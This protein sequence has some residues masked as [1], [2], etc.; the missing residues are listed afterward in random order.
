MIL[1]LAGEGKTDMG[2]MILHSEGWV[3]EPGPMAWM[4]DHLLA[5]QMGYSLIENHLSGA[6]CICYVSETDL[7]AQAKSTANKKS[8]RLPGLKWGKN[9]GY[10]NRNAQVLGLLALHKQLENQ[11]PVLAVLFRDAD[12]SRSTS[13]REWQDKWESIQRGFEMAQFGAGVPMVPRPKSEAWLLCALRQG[14]QHC[15]NLEEAPGND[16]SPQA[17]KIQLENWLGYRPAANEQIEWVRTLRVDPQRIL[18]PSFLVFKQALAKA[19]AYNGFPQK[20]QL[21]M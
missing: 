5:P 21:E 17:L 14:Y 3:F 11:T 15:N 12:A 8:T 19:A 1:M 6:E 2:Q 7:A 10:F 20:R 16:D 18:M 4:V 13:Q 9:T